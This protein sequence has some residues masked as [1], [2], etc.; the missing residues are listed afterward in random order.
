MSAGGPD[1]R[2]SHQAPDNDPVTIAAIQLAIIVGF[3][4]VVMLVVTWTR[5]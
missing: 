3:A 1:D 4:M 2:A 5:R